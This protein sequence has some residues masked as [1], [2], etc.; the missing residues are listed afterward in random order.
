MQCVHSIP[1]FGFLSAGSFALRAQ[2]YPSLFRTDL[3][4]VLWSACLIALLPDTEQPNCIRK[5]TVKCRVV[6]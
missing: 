5:T 1:V 2:T 4:V 3:S 6:I